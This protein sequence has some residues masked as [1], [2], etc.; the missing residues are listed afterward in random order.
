MARTEASI[1]KETLNF[2]CFQIGVTVAFLAQRTGQAENRIEAWLDTTSA[3]FPTI[4]QAKMLAKVLKIPFAG[5]YMDKELL[6]IKQL[7]TLKNLRTLPYRVVTDNSALNLAVAELIRYHELLTSS[8]FELGI[9]VGTLSLPV[10]SDYINVSECANTI[11]SFFDI[12]LSDQ[13][14]LTSPRQFYLYVRQKIEK[15]GVF[16]HCFTGVDVETVRGIS[17]FNTIAPIIGV[18]DND[19]HPAK[20]F[21]YNTRVGSYHETAVNTLQR[22]GC[23]ILFLNRGGVLQCR[24]RR[25]ACTNN[26]P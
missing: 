12:V 21:S 5:L 6:P 14:K 24:G 11:R 22:N 13:F 19:R 2:I 17:I 26:F 10:I 25:S 18:N 7:P 20:T 15:K 8:E 3:D 16:V 9:E 4:I 1:N 23:F